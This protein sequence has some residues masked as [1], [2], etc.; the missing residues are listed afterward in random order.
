MNAARDIEELEKKLDGVYDL[1]RT[2]DCR[3]II[4]VLLRSIRERNEVCQQDRQSLKMLSMMVLN[5]NPR[6]RTKA[7]ES[8]VTFKRAPGEVL[9]FL[10]GMCRTMN[11]AEKLTTEKLIT[12]VM[13]SVWS[14]LDASSRESALLGELVYRMKKLVGLP[15][16]SDPEET[17]KNKRKGVKK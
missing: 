9:G 17:P 12:E 1:T 13:N 5:G 2:E 3:K 10:M 8:M 16:S 6:A 11:E 7:Q 15:T 14:N 4:G